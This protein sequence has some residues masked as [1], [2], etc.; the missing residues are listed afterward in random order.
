MYIGRYGGMMLG[1]GFGFRWIIMLGMCLF[2][3]ACVVALFIYIKRSRNFGY[4]T[5]VHTENNSAINI[6]NE[7]YARGEITEEEYKRVKADITN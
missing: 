2:V 4:H 5:S 7:R 3:V 6:L 1:N